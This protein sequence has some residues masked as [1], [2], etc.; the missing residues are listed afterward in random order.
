MNRTDKEDGQQA[1]RTDR[2]TIV[3]RTVGQAD[4]QVTTEGASITANGGKPRK[5]YQQRPQDI[6]SNTLEG[7]SPAESTK[8]LDNE[9]TNELK[10]RVLTN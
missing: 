6:R 5:R 8:E 7:L 4:E 2:D 3:L 9:V 10:S 1:P